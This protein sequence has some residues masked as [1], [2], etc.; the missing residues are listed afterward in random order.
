MVGPLALALSE[1]VGP[2]TPVVVRLVAPVVV[3]LVVA[4]VCVAPPLGPPVVPPTPAALVAPP[5]P[6]DVAELE[7][8]FDVRFLPNPHFEPRLRP[9]NGRD[10]EVAGYVLENAR[11][12][13]FFD[14]LVGWLQFLLPLYDEEGKAY[15][16]IGLGCTGAAPPHADTVP[17]S[18]PSGAITMMARSAPA[19]AAVRAAA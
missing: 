3:K 15:V 11:G 18:A 17:A 2:V 13:E 12:A 9:R 7:L 1:F 8:L 14:R 10:A 19:R 4:A 16:T 5:I 6:S